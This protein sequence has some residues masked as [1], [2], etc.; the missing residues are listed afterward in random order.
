[1]LRCL[2]NHMKHCLM[3]TQF[4]ALNISVRLREP[5]QTRHAVMA[6]DENRFPIQ[7]SFFFIYSSCLRCCRTDLWVIGNMEYI[8]SAFKTNHSGKCCAEE[9][10]VWPVLN[11]PW[12][13]TATFVI[14]LSVWNIRVS[15]INFRYF[16]YFLL[17]WLIQHC[18]DLT[19]HSGA[20]V[21]PFFRKWESIKT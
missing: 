13:L 15:M 3:Q 6:C 8:D 20:Y 12:C 2:I 11:Y 1:M 18:H 7:F 5:W 14:I 10:D 19:K 17:L 16:L 9:I 21:F 4:D